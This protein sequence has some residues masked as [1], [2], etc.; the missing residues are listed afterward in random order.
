MLEKGTCSWLPWGSVS[1][2][3]SL[4]NPWSKVLASSYILLYVIHVLLLAQQN[5]YLLFQEAPTPYSEQS[6]S[7]VS[8][9]LWSKWHFGLLATA[10]CLTVRTFFMAIGYLIVKASETHLLEQSAV[11]DSLVPTTPKLKGFG[12]WSPFF[13]WWH[14]YLDRV[15]MSQFSDIS[16]HCWSCFCNDLI[17]EAFKHRLPFH[18][19]PRTAGRE[20]NASF[21]LQITSVCSSEVSWNSLNQKSD[22]TSVILFLLWHK[23]TRTLSWPKPTAN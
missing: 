21:W 8:L 7:A 9:S 4:L 6:V 12:Y 11:T 13:I 23:R 20:T 10:C 18:W 19:N 2:W 5:E 14:F 15:Q 17:H 16:N 3:R 1:W 22:S